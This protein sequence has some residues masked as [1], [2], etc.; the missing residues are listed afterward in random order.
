MGRLSLASWRLLLFA[1]ITVHSRSLFH[2]AG[3][4]RGFERGPYLDGRRA[5]LFECTAEQCCEGSRGALSLRVETV[6]N[7]FRRGGDG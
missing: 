5:E 7:T 3:L 2:N 6:A 1:S 4:S